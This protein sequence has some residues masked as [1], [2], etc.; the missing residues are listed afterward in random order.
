MS[1]IAKD[2]E[3]RNFMQKSSDYAVDIN[4]SEKV[5]ENYN[6]KKKKMQTGPSTTVPLPHTFKANVFKLVNIKKKTM[7][8]YQCAFYP[9]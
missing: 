9:S 4:M 3:K 8:T 1:S 5:Q 2:G 7:P 6:K